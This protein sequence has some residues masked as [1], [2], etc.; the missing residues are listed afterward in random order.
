MF[1]V[2]VV[3]TSYGVWVIFEVSVFDFSQPVVIDSKET[4]THKELACP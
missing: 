4:A 1:I 2:M 3:L